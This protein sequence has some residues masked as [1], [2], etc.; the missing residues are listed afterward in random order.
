MEPKQTSLPPA[1]YVNFLRVGQ[2]RAEFHLALGQMV[3]GDNAGAHLLGSFVTT[4]IHAKAMM[5]A[6]AEAV[7]RYEARYEEI[8]SPPALKGAEA[9]RTPPH[10]ARAQRG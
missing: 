8:P 7:E 2:D 6:L 4:P 1:A 10:Q 3:Q 9:P 5:K